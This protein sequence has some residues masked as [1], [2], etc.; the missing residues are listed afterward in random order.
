MTLLLAWGGDTSWKDLESCR[1]SAL[2]ELIQSQ[3]LASPLPSLRFWDA[4]PEGLLT[5]DVCGC[6]CTNDNSE[7]CGFDGASVD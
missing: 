3:P 6:L 4:G 2:R 7:A 1:E 5:A